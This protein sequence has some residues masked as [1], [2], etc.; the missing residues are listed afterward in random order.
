MTLTQRLT[1]Y[2]RACFTGLWIESHEH[3]DA[4]REIAQLCAQEHW[5]LATWNVATGLSIAG[6]ATEE[7]SASDPLAAIRALNTLGSQDSAALLVLVNFHRFLGSAEVVQALVQ[8]ISAGKQNRTFVVVLSPLVQIPIELEK[9]FAVIEH[10][11]PTREQL[12]EIAAGIATDSGEF[13]QSSE[14]HRVLDAASGLTRYEAGA[15]VKSCGRRDQAACFF[16]PSVNVTPAITSWISS[17]LFNRRHRFCAD[18]ASL[19]TIARHALREPF[20][21]VLR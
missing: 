13:P 12:Q 1:E 6:G 16:S 14:L 3:E 20:P 10:E 9:L 19:K 2:V 18:S 5:K 21:F 17:C 11:L 8:Q 15:M 7:M 4:L